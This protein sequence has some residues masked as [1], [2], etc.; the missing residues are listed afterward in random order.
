V[1]DAADPLGAA[2]PALR[3]PH[4][5]AGLAR[6]EDGAVRC[7][8]GHAFDVARHGYLSLLAGGGRGPAGDTAAMVAAREA[9]LGAGHFGPLAD[10][11]ADAAAEAGGPGVVVDLGAGTG[12]YLAGA[13]ERAPERIG[14]A[15]D[16]SKPALRRA[17]RAHPRMAAVAADA[18]RDLPLR[19][20]TAA[21][22]LSV[23]APR[24]GPEI[25]RVLAPGGRLVV[26]A[27]TTAHLAELVEP[28]GLL[29]VDERKDE[30]LAAQLPEPLRE[31]AR[32]EVVWTMA[33]SG[34]EVAELVAMG[35]SAFH[36][37]PAVRAQ[38]IAALGAPVAVTG[39]VTVSLHE[40]RRGPHR[41][42]TS[43]A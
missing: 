29:R 28:L 14:L 3:C 7:A 31:V 13:L 17:A 41:A 42:S 5:G 16:V 26:A 8:A 34:A 2:L 32:T 37:E 10:A 38:R 39:A 24:N 36:G 40:R 21:V 25:A 22:V 27:P 19:D 35:P 12:A 11:V 15:L 4:C 1:A 9:F 33:L 30:R 23:F 18:W 43:S 20:G 6:A